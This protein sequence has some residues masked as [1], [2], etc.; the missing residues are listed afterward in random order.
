[1]GQKYNV[2]GLPEAMH[3]PG[4][5]RLVLKN[6]LGIKKKSEMDRLEAI[7]LKQAEDLVFRKYGARHCFTAKD[8]CQMH[9]LWLGRIYPV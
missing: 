6:M 5:H 8:I 1:M 2:K 4:S 3:E 7:A 9:K